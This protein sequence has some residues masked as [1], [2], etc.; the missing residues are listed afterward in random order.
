MAKFAPDTVTIP[1]GIETID[2]KV[3]MLTIN[4]L[5]KDYDAVMSSVGHLTGVFGPNEI[6]PEGLTLEK[7]L[8]DLGW[9]QKEFELRRSFAYT[10]MSPDES[11]CLGCVYVDPS[12]KLDYDAMVIMW[13][14]QSEEG[15]GFDEKLF[16]TVKTWLSEKWWFTAVAFPGREMTW[17]YWES[18]SN[19]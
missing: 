2:F 9:H 19:K 17:H 16:S 11:K 8:V 15:S 12:E 3:R 13:V 18:L 1:V 5:V 10:V 14:R 4:D 7:E 6:W